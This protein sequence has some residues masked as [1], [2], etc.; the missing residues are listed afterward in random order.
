MYN[1]IAINIV[2]A[3]VA[4]FSKSWCKICNYI[5][6]FFGILYAIEM[7]AGKVSSSNMFTRVSMNN[8][9]I[10]P[11][12]VVVGESKSKRWASVTLSLGSGIYRTIQLADGELKY[13]DA[14]A[15]SEDEAEIIIYKTGVNL[16]PGKTG[17]E[18]I[19]A[20]IAALL[21][22]G[23]CHIYWHNICNYF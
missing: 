9:L 15:S 5:E 23:R 2:V 6:N 11:G 22:T 19:I 16:P 17:R 14:S 12:A 18:I 21:F 10:P 8:K 13:W 1:A 3:G 20:A 7:L 4:E